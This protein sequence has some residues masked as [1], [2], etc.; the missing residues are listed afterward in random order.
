VDKKI[1]VIGY[2][3]LGSPN[4]PERDVT[5]EDVSDMELEEVREIARSR[6]IHP[7]QVC[8]MW[9]V[10]KGA[11]PIPFSGNEKNILVNLRSVAE[12]LT[13]EEMAVL[14]HAERNCRLVKGQVFLWPCAKSWKELWD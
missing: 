2:C 4:R 14:D 11:I 13:D 6:N 9:A 7:A 1:K 12:E 5:P 10:R 3:P 8:L